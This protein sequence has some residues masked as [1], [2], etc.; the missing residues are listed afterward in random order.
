[1]RRR[2]SIYTRTLL[3]ISAAILIIFIVLAAV[4]GA[5][6]SIS[7]DFQR[8][9]ELRRNAIELSKLTED[10]MDAGHTTFTSTDI[11]GHIAFAAR[12]TAAF[13]W[14]VNA[15][16]AIIYHTGI[17][18]DT[19]S[20]LER[21]G[22]LPGGDPLL[23]AEAQNRSRAVYCEAGAQTGFSSLLPDSAGWLV[24][25]SPLGSHGDLYT[26]EV[27][28]L[29]HQRPESLSSFLREHNV[30]I[31]FSLAFL[32]SLTIIIWLSRDITRPISEL[33]K[34][35]NSVY[36]GDLSAR[37]KLGGDGRTLTLDHGEAEEEADLD[38][39]HEDD[40]T[41][42][43]RTFN[44]LIA[45]FEER[46]QQHC[47]FLGNVSHDLRTPVTSIGGFVEGMRDGTIPKEKYAYYLDIIKDENNRLKR[48]IDDLFD[49]KG[50]D[51]TKGLKQE[52]FDLYDLVCQV[53]QSFE[54]MLYEKG[55][56][57]EINF[58][59]RFAAPLRAVGDRGQLT[60]VLNNIIANAVR[61]TP[62]DG[63]ILVSLEVGER[64]ISLSVDDNGPGIPAEDLP[65]IFDRF[66]KA[67]KSRGGEGSGLGLYI[68]RALVKR[69]GQEIE[70]GRSARL[71]GA[72]I[73]FTV[74]RP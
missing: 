54:P 23:P 46:E 72:R 55:I 37:V 18:A 40:L 52:V 44:T 2:L 69:H 29:K 38:Y 67:D 58:D 60:R 32:L 26:G 68:A 61:Y 36:A 16:G 50:L 47:E 51:D 24:A 10:R 14:I 1:M 73:S 64:F 33:A 63:L 11:T 9:E 31:S 48:L 42:L 30:P 49:G 25:S 22:D 28:L 71:G 74:A 70:A 6:Y 8:K 43:V 21:S 53:R 41:R 15:N 3:K 39:P 27:I 35:A 4:Y 20:Q 13:V 62:Q 34:T 19:I 66:Y 12:S 7:S 17:P 59:H 56:D 65:H 57:L 5:V 45:K